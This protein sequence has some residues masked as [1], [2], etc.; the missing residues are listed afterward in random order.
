MVFVEGRQLTPRAAVTAF[1]D[2]FTSPEDRLVIFRQLIEKSYEFA[3]KVTE[4]VMANTADFEDSPKIIALAKLFAGN[5]PIGT[6]VVTSPSQVFEMIMD[7]GNGAS[8]RITFAANKAGNVASVTRL[9]PRFIAFQETDAKVFLDECVVPSE[10][11]ERIHRDYV[12]TIGETQ[13]NEKELIAQGIA[14]SCE[15]IELVSINV[16][17]IGLIQKVILEEMISEQPELFY[18][19]TLFRQAAGL[20]D[21]AGDGCEWA[22]KIDGS[23]PTMEHMLEAVPQEARIH[24]LKEYINVFKRM[25]VV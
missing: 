1:K 19:E 5:R 10:S 20:L 18:D 13:L 22:K 17:R 24:F 9:A 6:K 2:K 15:K 16:A 7:G 14:A 4:F 3:A 23:N 8:F 25:L 12:I 11:F 21:R